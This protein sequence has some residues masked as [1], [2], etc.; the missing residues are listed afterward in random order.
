[1]GKFCDL[2]PGCIL[3][4][5][6]G[7]RFGDS[8]LLAPGVKVVPTN[9]ASASREIPIRHQELMPSKGGV[10]VE[11]DVWGGASA[12][13]LDGTPLEQD[14]IVAAGGVNSS[15]VP[16]FEVWGGVPARKIRERSE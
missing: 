7:I 3:C 8:V 9:H 1:M 10:V 11:D 12:A 5:G 15:R 4:S 16:A 2:K 6:D 14:A 13:L